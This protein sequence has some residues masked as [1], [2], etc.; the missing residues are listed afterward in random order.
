MN[1]ASLEIITYI[2][3]FQQYSR[4]LKICY[5]PLYRK[6]PDLPVKSH[7]SRHTS[8]FKVESVGLVKVKIS[9]KFIL[10]FSLFPL[11]STVTFINYSLTSRLAT[12][13]KNENGVLP[14]AKSAHFDSV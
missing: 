7:K 2:I 5:I 4:S 10:V 11:G 12:L 13:R 1:S 8:E 14:R 9:N 6:T 3:Q